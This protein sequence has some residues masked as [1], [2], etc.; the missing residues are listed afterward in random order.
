MAEE[1]KS[2]SSWF[3]RRIDAKTT[4]VVA[5]GFV[6]MGEDDDEWPQ[7]RSQRGRQGTKGDFIGRDLARTVRV[8]VGPWG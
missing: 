4:E 7:D 6:W 5:C 2:W 3:Q 1:R 8:P